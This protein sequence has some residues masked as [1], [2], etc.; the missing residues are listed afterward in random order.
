MSDSHK[1]L[2]TLFEKYQKEKALISYFKLNKILT[3]T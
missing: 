1:K 3:L 2:D